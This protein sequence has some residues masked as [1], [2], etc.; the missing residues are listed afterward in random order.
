MKAIFYRKIEPVGQS[1]IL[2]PDS[3]RDA[4]RFYD[5][6]WPKAAGQL[7]MFLL[8]NAP[9]GSGGFCACP[10]QAVRA[11]LGLAV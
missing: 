8:R 2:M 7:V 6:I 11:W 1:P 5:R 4:K 3:F 9:P 10:D